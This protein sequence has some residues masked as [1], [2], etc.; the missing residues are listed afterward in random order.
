MV[1][2]LESLAKNMVARPLT[3][4]HLMIQAHHHQPADMKWIAINKV[5]DHPMVFHF[6]NLTK[7]LSALVDLTWKRSCRGSAHQLIANRKTL[8]Q[9]WKN[10]TTRRKN[11]QNHLNLKKY[12]HQST[13]NLIASESAIMVEI[14]I[15][16]QQGPF[17]LQIKH[18]ATEKWK[19]S[20]KTLFYFFFENY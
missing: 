13:I 12:R 17:K 6:N 20:R 7:C 10:I 11:K 2:T 4:S 5:L 16:K 18:T 1:R 8:F 9:N 3:V 14:I 15:M 19:I